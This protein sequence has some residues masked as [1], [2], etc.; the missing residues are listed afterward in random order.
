VSEPI[1]AAE[2]AQTTLAGA[3]VAVIVATLGWLGTR[4][5][6]PEAA[7]VLVD[8]AVKLAQAVSSENSELREAVEDLRQSN[9]AF[10]HD[11]EA[12]RADVQ[13]MRVELDQ[14]RAEV[15]RLQIAVASCEAKHAKAQEAMVAAG[16]EIDPA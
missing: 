7:S 1:L 12:M 11:N 13:S 15:T 2:A 4:K 16:I 10:Q 9:L 5:S 3:A 6:R 14:G 8:S